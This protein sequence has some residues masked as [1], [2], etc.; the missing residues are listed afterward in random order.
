MIPKVHDALILNVD[1]TEAARYAKTRILA[2]AGFRVIEASSGNEALSRARQEKPDLVLLDVKLPDI[3][4][5]EVC[6]QL[7][8]DLHTQTILILQTSA[9]YIASADK[10]RALEGGADNYLFEPIEPEELIANVN[11]LLRLGKVERELREVDRRKDIFLATLAHELRN[12]LAPILTAAELLCVL[13][14]DVPEPQEHARQIIL[15]QTNYMIRL[16]DDLLDVSRITNGK[17]LLRTELVELHAFVNAA[18]ETAASIIKE[19]G[20][21]LVVQLPNFDVWVNGDRVRLVQIIGNLLNNAAKFTPQGGSIELSAVQADDRVHIKVH[22]NGIGLSESDTSIFDLFVQA[23]HAPDHAKD[24]LGIGLPLVKGLVELHGGTIR[25]TSPGEGKGSSFEVSLPVAQFNKETLNN[26]PKSIDVQAT[27]RRILIVDD[28]IDGAEMI[29][30][31]LEQQGHEIETAHTGAEALAKTA[32]FQ[33]EIVILDIGLP[34]MSGL[35]VARALRAREGGQAL[36]LIALTGFGRQD[37]KDS[38]YDAGFD[39][40][41]TKP[42][43]FEALHSAIASLMTAP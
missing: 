40:H 11:A 19:R 30:A 7:K 17:I 12:P 33:P 27:Q 23:G 14:P 34:D 39:F 41:L 22:D 2:R 21:T 29:S 1:D 42:V 31:L 15:R 35:D 25:A 28:N 38:A 37:D 18:V 9:S 43:S 10:I 6:K 36:R 4:G 20:H 3:N 26:V 13:D 8:A 16:V 24:G 32:D 5:F